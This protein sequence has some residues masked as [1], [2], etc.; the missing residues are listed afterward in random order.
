MSD[1]DSDPRWLRLKDPHFSAGA[2]R[3]GVFELDI[4]RPADWT[5]GEPVG[6]NDDFDP[7][8]FLSAD[9]CIMGDQRYFLRGVIELL[10]S[11]SGGSIFAH[12]GWVEVS[13]ASFDGYL[14]GQD[15]GA[16]QP[17]PIPGAFANR[18]PGLQ[19]TLREP[20]RL[21]PREGDLRPQIL[22]DN[23]FHPIG[24]AQANGL[25]LDALLDIYAGAGLDLRP[26]L[27]LSH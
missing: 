5:G 20:C 1:L 24:A 9:Y 12:G 7:K 16:P 18:L 11:G 8:N 17:Q 2:F 26:A 3:G 10:I 27:A 4:D 6:G 13:R 15:P 23:R 22:F 25:S 14:R 19:T 21:V